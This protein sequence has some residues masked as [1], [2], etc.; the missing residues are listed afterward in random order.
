MLQRGFRP[1]Q[2]EVFAPF[3]VSLTRL[4]G[5]SF[6]APAPH[7]INGKR[8]FGSKLRRGLFTSAIH[9]HII[10]NVLLRERVEVDTLTSAPAFAE[11]EI[12]YQVKR[13]VERPCLPAGFVFCHRIGFNPVEIPCEFV[14]PPFKT[15][16]MEIGG[17]VA[18]STVWR[19]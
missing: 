18:Q 4:A 10:D 15:I 3:S 2:T 7:G 12:E 14:L 19:F 13:T 16:Y 8:S 11:S 9:P 5:T 6:F 17:H 1:P